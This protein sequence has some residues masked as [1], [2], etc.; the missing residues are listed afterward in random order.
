M[1]ILEN[2]CDCFY[3]TGLQNFIPQVT[4]AGRRHISKALPPLPAHTHGTALEIVYVISGQIRYEVNNR[5]YP[6]KGGD[7]FLAFPHEIHGTGQHPEE[8]AS[9]CWIGV[10]IG[11]EKE[12]FLGFRNQEALELRAALR[13][14]RTR[15]FRGIP[16]IQQH[17]DCI[18]DTF[19]SRSPYR[20]LVA[21]SACIELLADI[22]KTEHTA[23]HT[24][25]CLPVLRAFKLIEE[26]LEEKIVLQEIAD[27]VH[28][29]LPH[30]KKVFREEVGMP[31]Y[32]YVLRRK[33]EKA[34]ELLRQPDIST[35]E[36]AF[37]LSFPSSQ[38][39]ATLFKKM[40]ALTPAAFR[41]QNPNAT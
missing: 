15:Q 9:F 39:F 41:K 20:K 23:P 11:L 19:L 8:R 14:M 1:E 6:V 29:S 34:K 5:F 36:I 32:E 22:L 33:M 37:R 17:M 28:I 35:T 26:R 18:I 10:D 31:P 16:A 2:R 3:A 40:N 4:H 38:H 25:I 7:I 12:S 24:Q 21:R 27:Q 13:E 30:L